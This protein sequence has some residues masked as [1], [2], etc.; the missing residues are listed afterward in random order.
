MG[1]DVV[2]RARLLVARGLVGLALCAPGAAAALDDPPCPASG[3]AVVVVTERRELW[4]CAQGAAATRFPVALGRSG[5]GK[6]RR[7]DD[8]TPL[9][10]YALG[11]P[12]R[13]TVYGTFIPIAYPTPAQTARGFTGSAVG[14]HGP[15]R[16][17][18][19]SSHPVTEVDWTHGCIATGT[20]DEVAAIA[21]FVQQR[22]PGIVI[23]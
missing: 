7:G 19:A 14:I 20:D 2:H 22:R 17:M 6:R 18:D 16:G 1:G 15:P 23:R 5:V 21:A 10:T 8:R 3:D 13:S 9:G 12:R 11:R 4:L